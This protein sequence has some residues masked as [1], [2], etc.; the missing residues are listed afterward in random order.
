MNKKAF[1][2][3]QNSVCSS[4]YVGSKNLLCFNQLK[5]ATHSPVSACFA[6]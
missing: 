4:K 6:R 1:L 2:Q 3:V 5:R